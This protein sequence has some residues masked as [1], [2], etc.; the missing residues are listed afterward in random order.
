[1]SK[2]KK[3]TEKWRNKY[4]LV[5]LN[6]ENFEEK[7]SLK[8]SRLNVFVILSLGSVILI[9]GT[10]I[11][12]AFTP[13]REYIPG[14]SSTALKRQAYNNAIRVDSL[15]TT[16]AQYEQYVNII[17]GV[18]TDD[19]LEYMGDTIERTRTASYPTTGFTLDPSKEDSILR[20]RVEHEEA[21]N[22]QGN[23]T[24]SN[25]LLSY[26]F[27][28]PVRGEIIQG[29]LPE[30]NHFAV[31]IV[32]RSNEPVKSCLKGTVLFAE[33]SAQTG[34]TI[35]IQHS[36]N[37]TS[38]YKHNSTLFKKQGDRVRAG[39]VIAI[40]GNTGELTTGPHLHF[41]LWYNGQPLNPEDYLQF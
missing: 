15:E 25:P 20:L 7:L 1:M 26:A 6:D 5:I 29:F 17:R 41:E 31:D 32:T 36:N 2:L 28:T 4:R 14:Y 38:V 30:E 13:L 23:G 34:Y 35:V 3:I 11:L 39:E 16:L 40:I 27:F 33:F 22:I 24:R 8:L 18:V 37:L 19:P 9:T 21:F 12:I 10:I